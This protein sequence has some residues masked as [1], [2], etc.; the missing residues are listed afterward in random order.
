MAAMCRAIDV[1]RTSVPTVAPAD[2][3]ARAVELMKDF[4]VR[5]LP[6]VEGDAVVGILARSDTEP[7]VGHLEWTPVRVAMSSPVRTV[8]HDAPIAQ[9]ARALLDGRF[10]G[11]PVLVGNVLAGMITRHDLLQLLVGC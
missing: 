10:N 6:V 5:E 2:S 7:H 3:L 1:M 8:G 4:S 11:I 9:V